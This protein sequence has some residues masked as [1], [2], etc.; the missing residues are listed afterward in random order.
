MERG[1]AEQIASE[2]AYN[3]TLERLEY[4]RRPSH[5]PAQPGSRSRA[6]CSMTGSR[7]G[8]MLLARIVPFVSTNTTLRVLRCAARDAPPRRRAAWSLR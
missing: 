8:T 3:R 4:V 1:H 2:L 5:P 7:I 6:P